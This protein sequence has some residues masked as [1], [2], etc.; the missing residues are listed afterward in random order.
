MQG[1]SANEEE[2]SHIAAINI[3]PLV[4]VVLVL[5]IIF[6]ITSVFTKE[7]AMKLEL[8]K[9]S[10]QHPDVPPLIV[11]VNVDSGSNITVNGKP[12][13]LTDLQATLKS[14]DDSTSTRKTDVVLRGDKNVSYGTI[15]PILDNI[16]R[17]GMN[18][19][20]ALKPPTGGP[21]S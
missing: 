6:M 13:Q 11:T 18:L 19:S 2:D 7:T 10:F 1:P 5:L 9:S 17:T 20:L 21:S 14:Y 12:C 4:D 3:I 16:S 15:I 8:P